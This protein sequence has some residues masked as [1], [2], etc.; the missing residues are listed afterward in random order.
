MTIFTLRQLGPDDSAEAARVH[1]ASFN[2][3]LPWLS[4]LH[5]PQEDHAFWRDHLLTECSVYGAF[6]NG[7][8]LGVIAFRSGWIDQ[9]YVL[10]AAQGQ[11]IGAA[12]LSKAKLGQISLDLWT[13]QNTGPARRFYESHGFVAV[14]ETDGQTN[15]EREPDVRYRWLA[16]GQAASCAT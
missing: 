13:F 4:D 10:P 11:G 15:E 1:R 16:P 3:R 7:H 5:T 2:D 14:E 8:L 12:L 9:L 6:G